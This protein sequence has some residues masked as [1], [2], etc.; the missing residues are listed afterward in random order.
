M[1]KNQSKTVQRENFLKISSLLWAK[2]FGPH[3]DLYGDEK[4]LMRHIQDK[5]AEA[6]DDK[7]KQKQILIILPQNWSIA[8]IENLFGASNRMVRSSKDLLSKDGFL[9]YPTC[10]VGKSTSVAVIDCVDNFYKDD[11]NS[12]MMPGK[13]DCVTISD[14]GL[15]KK[16]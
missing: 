5:F 2:L 10:K 7:N 8:K 1:K 13:K 15:K 3:R 4:E 11:D 9:G 16:I 6:Q 12:R 14:Q